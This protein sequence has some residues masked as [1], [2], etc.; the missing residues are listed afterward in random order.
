MAQDARLSR[1]VAAMGPNGRDPRHPWLVRRRLRPRQRAQ[2]SELAL[3]ESPVVQP[4]ERQGRLLG[5]GG[6][7]TQARH[8]TRIT[9]TR[10]RK[11]R[12]RSRPMTS[13]PIYL[14]NQATTPLD[15]RALESMLPY[16]NTMF[17][18]ASSSHH[19]GQEAAPATRTARQ[20]LCSL[21]GARSDHEIVFTSG[22]TESN[23]LAIMGTAMALHSRGDH[24]VTTAIEH[25]SVLATCA[26]LEQ[27]G[28][29][30][31]YLPVNQTGRVDPASVEQA[32]TAGTILVSVMHANNENDTVQPVHEIGAVTRRLGVAFHTHAAQSIGSLAIDV[33][34]RN[35]DLASLSAHKIYGPKGVGALYVR[36]PLR[37]GIALTPQLL[38]GGQEHG[39][40]HLREA[41]LGALRGVERHEQG[42]EQRAEH[43]RDRG[44]REVEAE[45]DA[46]RAGGEADQLGVAHEPDRTQVPGRAVALAAGDVVDGADFNAQWYRCAGIDGRD[47]C[48][49]HRHP[50]WDATGDWTRR[51]PALSWPTVASGPVP[52]KLLLTCESP[53][54]RRHASTA[55]R[56][57][58]SP[59]AAPAWR[60]ARR[61]TAPWQ[62]VRPPRREPSPSSAGPPAGSGRR[63]PR[64][65]PP[66]RW[67][68]RPARRRRC[69][70][71]PG[72]RG[73]GRAGPGPPSSPAPASRSGRR[74]RPPSPRRWSPSPGPSRR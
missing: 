56:G 68:D 45:A 33:A 8:Q 57:R 59:P 37:G 60:R 43:D 14:D 32:I 50:S 30:I 63:P 65:R 24:I 4:R 17:G 26:R 25:K 67:P 46:D 54:L 66:C 28:F 61:R 72:W 7:R 9:P 52:R 11:P 62:A 74:A 16:L 73:P 13:R 64:C 19:Y 42:A 20:Q 27:A 41:E 31:T 5:R 71:A 3:P 6:R 40:D 29:T 35:V 51:R 22:A 10:R 2:G 18:N 12:R 55:N 38:G 53:R 44:P 15:P 21:L 1:L 36:P 70:R 58:Q 47:S 49:S 48:L 23:N 39:L 69:G 34:E